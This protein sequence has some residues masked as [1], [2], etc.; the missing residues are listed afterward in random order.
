MQVQH[1][2]GAPSAHCPN[3]G[4][5]TQHDSQVTRVLSA[6]LVRLGVEAAH[7]QAFLS[8]LGENLNMEHVVR[9]HAGL[10]D[11]APHKSALFATMAHFGALDHYLRGSNDRAGVHARWDSYAAFKVAVGEYCQVCGF[12]SSI[13]PTGKRKL[14][15]GTGPTGG[16]VGCTHKGCAFNLL[17]KVNETG[18]VYV[19]S[20][21]P[22]LK[23]PVFTCWKHGHLLGPAVQLHMSG[24][25][26]TYVKSVGDLKRAEVLP[27]LCAP[28]SS[29]DHGGTASCLVLAA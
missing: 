21:R 5:T 14:D 11:E 24:G 4:A 28:P 18:A 2:H 17:F 23:G 13:K 26:S 29:W 22:T 3:T 6:K 10:S 12:Q 7:A 9:V 27:C 20:D 19:E 25:L 8:Q 16:H 15:D 1:P